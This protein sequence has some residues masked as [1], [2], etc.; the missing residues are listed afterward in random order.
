M[1]GSISEANIQN[2]DKA[3][4]KVDEMHKLFSTNNKTL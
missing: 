3:A 1:F 4:K 2:V